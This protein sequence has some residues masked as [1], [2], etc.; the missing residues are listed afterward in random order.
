MQ[1]K[2]FSLIFYGALALIPIVLFFRYLFVALLPFFA[3]FAAASLL[4][5]PSRKISKALKIPYKAV[6]VFLTVLSVSV[7]MGILG[8]LLWKTA[9]EIGYFAGET[10]GG[11]N[12]LLDNVMGI[13]QRMGD[14]LSALPFASEA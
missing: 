7:F 4:H 6:A 5:R 11:E 1:K 10:L 3:A 14:M 9:S 12:G 2:V 8:F 13:F